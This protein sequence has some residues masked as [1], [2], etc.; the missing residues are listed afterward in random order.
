ML[1]IFNMFEHYESY[2]KY[3]MKPFYKKWSQKITIIIIFFFCKVI[4]V[5]WIFLELL[6]KFV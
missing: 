1:S 5:I 2:K 6:D 4:L 3:I